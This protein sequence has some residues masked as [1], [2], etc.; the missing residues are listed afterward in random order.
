MNSQRV[1]IIVL[2]GIALLFV[3]S[4]VLGVNNNRTQPSEPRDRYQA[5]GF[6]KILGDLLSPFS[7]SVRLKQTS[8]VLRPVAPVI[9]I[10][11]DSDQAAFRKLEFSVSPECSGVTIEYVAAPPIAKP[12][13]KLADQIWP[14]ENQTD[15]RGNLIILKG[16]GRL[17]LTL[18]SGVSAPH[19][20][21][22]K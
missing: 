11:L 12:I 9:P 16:G 21:L 4:I 17:T 5:D 2:V 14:T 6:S 7:P 1:V 20:V 19:T 13:E 10:S 22:F 15:C 18:K 8:F 3:L